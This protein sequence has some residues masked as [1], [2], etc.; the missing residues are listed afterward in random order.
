MGGTRK[1]YELWSDGELKAALDAYL[2]ML[3]LE[4]SS[5]P[6]SATEYSEA[7]LCGLLHKRNEASIRYRMRNISHVVSERGLP[8]LSAFSSAPQVGRNVIRRIN[9]LL[10]ARADTIHAIR[11]LGSRNASDVGLP[12]VLRSLLELKNR[13]SALEVGFPV[14]IGHNNP[15]D[16]IDFSGE[17]VTD[18]ATAIDS[19]GKEI[20]DGQPDPKVVRTLSQQ[21]S[22]FG[23]K[24]WVWSGQRLTDFAKA[25]AVAA[26]TGFGLS[27]SGLGEQIVNTLRSL[28]Q[29]AF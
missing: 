22:A 29:L 23:L 4:L 6:F 2:Y 5:I 20:A 18:V 27:I 12:D 7:L 26:G 21:V 11:Q 25:G 14:G 9:E 1:K 17:E 15:P 24:V 8:T 10:D 19:I 16:S 28:F 3:Q 13:I